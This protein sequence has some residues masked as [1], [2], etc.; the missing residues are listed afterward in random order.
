MSIGFRVLERAR[1]VDAE[2]VARYREVPVAN[3]SDSMNRMTAGGAKV[4]PMHRAGV[5]AGAALTVK[6]RPGDNLMLHYALDIAEP[7]D[8]VV[9]DAGG[10]LS[11][12]LIG[13]MMVA[14]AIKRGVAGIVI[15]GAIRD[16]AVIG[17]GDFPLFAAG[18]SHRGPYKDGPGEINVPIA[19]DGMVIEPGDLVIGDDDGLLCVPF[20]QVGEVFDRASAKHAAECKQMEQIAQGTN[21]RTWVLESLKKKGCLLP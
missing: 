11:N 4:R 14:Y 15:N 13:E 7:G 8:V 16:S 10:D 17:A 12:A 6:A 19:I 1:K 5:L 20:D 18:I 3:V 9:V 2:W 21:D